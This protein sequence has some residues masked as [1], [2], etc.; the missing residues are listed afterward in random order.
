MCLDGYGALQI[1][2]SAESFSSFPLSRGGYSNEEM[3]KPNFWA[4]VNVREDHRTRDPQ[5]LLDTRGAKRR[6]T[7]RAREVV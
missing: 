1:A 7:P 3:P 5:R 2:G 6:N 4:Y